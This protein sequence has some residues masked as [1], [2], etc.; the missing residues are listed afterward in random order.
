MLRQVKLMILANAVFVFLYGFFNWAEYSMLTTFSKTM[1]QGNFP[2]YI[3]ITEITSPSN[4]PVTGFRSNLF[5]NYPLV[6]FLLSTILNMYFIFRLQKS[7]E[8]KQNPT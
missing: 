2:F 6:I 4:P 5:L 8:T 1:I 3:L 7:K